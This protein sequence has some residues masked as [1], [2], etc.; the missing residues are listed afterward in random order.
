MAETQII[1]TAK[2]LATNVFRQ[3]MLASRDLTGALKGVGLALAGSL[4]AERLVSM[5]VETVKAQDAMG[6]LAQATGLSVE[7]ISAYSYAAQI[8]GSNTQALSVGVRAL[9]KN[10]LEAQRAGSEASLVFRS[11][12]VSTK[13]A[14][15]KLRSTEQILADIADRFASYE[16]GPAKVDLATR[17]FGRSGNELI[18][19]LNQG[20]AGM[21][22]LSEEARK[23]GIVLSSDMVAA[24]ARVNDGLERLS[25]RAEGV[26]NRIVAGLL[27]A[28]E[29]VMDIMEESAVSSEGM[30]STVSA[31]DTTFR[32][33]ASTLVQ[34]KNYMLDI[35]WD[36]A[37]AAAKAMSGDVSGAARKLSE[38]YDDAM[39]ADAKRRKLSGESGVD[40]ST[41]RSR[42]AQA[43]PDI[44]T[45]AADKLAKA[46]KLRL[47]AMAAR[48]A[49]VQL[50]LKA[51][52]TAASLA[53]DVA[54]AESLNR[55]AESL[56]NLATVRRELLRLED[57]RKQ[58]ETSGKA[59]PEA[60]AALD[61][62]AAALKA[63]VPVYERLTTLASTL[64]EIQERARV[65]EQASAHASAMAGFTGGLGVW[66][67]RRQGIVSKYDTLRESPATRQFSGDWNREQA[68]ALAQ[69]GREQALAASQASEASA[70]MRG[71]VSGMAQA[72]MEQLEIERQLATT[73][74]QRALLTA[75]IA[76]A[77]ARRDGDMAAG[78][79]KGF[80]E[81]ASS[82]TDAFGQAESAAV[83]CFSTMSSGFSRAIVMGDSLGSTLQNLSLRLMDMSLEMQAFGPLAKVMSGSSFADAGGIFSIFSA[84]GNAFQSADLAAM[85]GRIVTRPTVFGF[86][87]HLTPFAKGGGVMGEAG[88]EGIFKL[89]RDQDGVLGV[90]GRLDGRGGTYVFSPNITVN[91]P[92]STGNQARDDAHI[93][94]LTASLTKGLEA[95]FNDMLDKAMRPGGKLNRGTSL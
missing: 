37:M 91:A 90:K 49:L 87:R 63:Q 20:S 64:A 80:R 44:A 2:D 95:S 13:D 34:V 5:T 35:P 1:I 42:V 77:Q 16:E 40:E 24:A 75:Q 73:E 15:G 36:I 12:G 46:S 83:S 57:E 60:L 69:V 29:D 93:K 7:S 32:V 65:R 62:Q 27:P 56:K 71:N 52:A 48:D 14:E 33:F 72:Q 38:V 39:E 41:Y 9:S 6:K 22:R 25:A 70:R 53:G 67:V 66:D 21:A 78:A 81:Y 88:P 19:L 68:A 74:E 59:T 82:A 86:D 84:K 85:S 43:V 55:Q 58:L 18:P 76:E 79:R 17:L 3:V 26:K 47:E 54:T 28:L 31:V 89:F 50:D 94:A 30:N 92:P 45:D 23:A 10:I 61:D 4:S 8:S 51:Q 11:I